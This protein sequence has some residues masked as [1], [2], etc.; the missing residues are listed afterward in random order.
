MSSA[1]HVPHAALSR[2]GTRRAAPRRGDSS[3]VLDVRPVLLR[4]ICI[5]AAAVVVVGC[6]VAAVLLRRGSGAATFQTSDQ[7]S[8][9]GIGI[10]A[11]AGLMV[12][13]RPHL[14]AD[15]SGLWVRNIFGTHEVPWE[16]V[17]AVRFPHKAPWAALEFPD[18]ELL[19]VL[20]L[21]AADGDRAV[22]ALR[23][24]R[25]MLERYGPP[26]RADQAGQGDSAS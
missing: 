12:L 21:Q 1:D 5:T 20:A 4:R 22:Q 24:L 15:A 9:V 18:D 8:V 10:A 14:I 16:L 7:V 2:A 17:R 11:A 26:G 6:T 13:A 3:D 19:S 25:A 23:A